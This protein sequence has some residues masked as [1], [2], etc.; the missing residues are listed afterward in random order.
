MHGVCLR[1]T[2]QPLTTAQ[3]PADGAADHDNKAYSVEVVKDHKGK[4]G[5]C[6]AEVKLNLIPG[7][8]LILF[9]GIQLVI[10]VKANETYDSYAQQNAGNLL[11]AL[12]K[13]RFSEQPCLV[14]LALL[15]HDVLLIQESGVPTLLLSQRTLNVIIQLAWKVEHVAKVPQDRV[16]YTNMCK[17]EE[18]FDQGLPQAGL[19]GGNEAP[20]DDLEYITEHNR[21]H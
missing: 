8:V 5:R 16:V 20:S 14:N 9:H 10:E 13:D 21:V 1:V 18:V 2:L 19:F 4:E 17:E 6:V 15:L 3:V 11:D 12:E 7:R